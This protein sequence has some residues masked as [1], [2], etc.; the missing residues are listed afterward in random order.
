M[1]HWRDNS[2][3]MKHKCCRWNRTKIWRTNIKHGYLEWSRM[4]LCM[5]T[6]V[7]KIWFQGWVYVKKQHP[8]AYA[9]RA[10][11]YSCHK[12]NWWDWTGRSIE[13]HIFKFSKG[14]FRWVSKVSARLPSPNCQHWDLWC[15]VY[16][17]K[18]RCHGF[19]DEFLTISRVEVS[20]VFEVESSWWCWILCCAN[21]IDF[22]SWMTKENALWISQVHYSTKCMGFNC[23]Y[24]LNSS[25]VKCMED[26]WKRVFRE[27][28]EGQND[29]CGVST[30]GSM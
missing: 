20:K 6:G 23:S 5:L 2:T 12:I 11:P 4:E 3:F 10:T 24:L 22:R 17:A 26:F 18:H 29:E 15:Q 30:V 19:L 21:S 28:Q 8:S 14:Y 1:Q 16:V 25:R 9:K 7:Y 27:T 13:D